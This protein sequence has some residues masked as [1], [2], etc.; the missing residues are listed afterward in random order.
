M[1]QGGTAA[2]AAKNEQRALLVEQMRSLALYVQEASGNVLSVLLSSGFL[3]AS[4]NRA[5][6]PLTTPT[7]RK[8]TQTG[9]GIRVVDVEVVDMARCY[10]IN[11]A[12]LDENGN[13]GPFSTAGLFT[14]SR[15]IRI[16]GLISGTNYLFQARAIGG[17]TGY[18]NWCNPVASMSF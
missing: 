6:A 10:E 15:N 14:R 2:T 3:A 5:S 18:S 16:D 1:A 17:S 4:T 12:T 8:I 7:I 11:I 13:P 9:P